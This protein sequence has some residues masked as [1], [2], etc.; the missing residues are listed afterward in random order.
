MN[1]HQRK[2]FL[3]DVTFYFWDDPF[4][5]KQCADRIIRRYV[6]EQEMEDILN[7]CHA[8]EYGGHFGGERTAM[9][10]LQSGFY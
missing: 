5:F 1:S 3:H 2:K 9:K 7:H 8:S 10:V 6:P 4:L